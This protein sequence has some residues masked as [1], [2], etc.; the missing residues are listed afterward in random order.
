MQAV[1]MVE[2]VNQKSTPGV[3]NIKNAAMAFTVIKVNLH[4]RNIWVVALLKTE[5]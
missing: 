4:F 1:N 2:E 3:R 5:N